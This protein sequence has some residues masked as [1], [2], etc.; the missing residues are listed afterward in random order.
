MHRL[1]ILSYIARRF[2][3][4]WKLLLSV[5]VGVLVAATLVAGAP[6]Y[7]RTLERQGLNTAIDRSPRGFLN[8]H[9]ASDYIPLDREGINGTERALDPA[10]E[11]YLEGPYLGRQRYLRAPVYY[12]G[13]PHRPLSV[14]QGDRV[15]MGHFQYMSELKDH[16]TFVEGR[17]ATDEVIQG[18]EGVIIEAVIGRRPA[19][20]L[21]LEV[22]DFATLT[23]SLRAHGYV[24]AKIV[25]ILEPIDPTSV[26]WRGNA[27]IFVSP[28]TNVQAE[29]TVN[30]DDD[31]AV[32]EGGPD[33]DPTMPPMPLFTTLASLTDGV[34]RQYPGTLVSS[35]W[36]LYMDKERLKGWSISDTRAR[37]EGLETE[38]VRSMPG[39]TVFS[40]MS[41]LVT[42]FETRNFF[43]TV[44][45]LLL[46]AIM[47]M[48]V[49]YYLS[50]MVSYLVQSR[51]KDV[52]LLRS[53]GVS[54]FQ[55]LRL[56]AVEGVA[57]IALATVLAPFIAM[58]AVAAA[59]ILPY[60][61][62]ITGGGLL[63]VQLAWE[64]FAVAA[65]AGIL[66][67]ATFVV[68][69]VVGT[70]IGLVVHRLRSSRP[71]SVPV[72]QRYY[73]DVA[74]LVIGGLIFWEL[75]SR[76]HLVAGGLFEN[77]GVN[78]ALLLAPVLFLAM[79]ALV[80]MRLFPLLVRYA[81]GES[82][83][84]LHP[85]VAAV[86]ATLASTV[87][88]SGIEDAAGLAWL[89]SVGLLG[90]VAVAYWATVR[91]R[92][93]T[94]RVWGL[95]VQSGLVGLFTVVEPP[96]IGELGFPAAV[97]LVAIV[98]AQVVFLLLRLGARIWPVSL[99][100]GLWH[101][102]R[103]PLQYSWLILLLVLVTGLGVMATT[104]GGTLERSHQERVSYVV[105][106]D[107]RISNI[108][109]YKAGNNERL[110][111]EYL[112]VPGVT[113]VTMALRGRARLG[114][115]EEA[116]PFEVLAVE[117]AFF[118]RSSWY[119]DDFSPRSLTSV[120]GSLQ[121][122][123]PVD[124]I[125]LPMG[126]T[127]LGVWIKPFDIY[128]GVSLWMVLED[129]NGWMTTLSFGGLGEP[130]WHLVRTDIPDFMEPPL[131]ILAV[132][133]TER[134]FGPTATPGTIALDD[135]HV[136]LGESGEVRV[137]D[138]FDDSKGWTPM[139][140]SVI[141]TDTLSLTTDGAH[142]GNAAVLFTFGKETDF[143][144]RG[145]YRTHHA[146]GVPVVASSSFVENTGQ[147]IGSRFVVN[148]SGRLV[149]VF[150]QD[151][152][153]YFPTLDPNGGGFLLTNLDGLMWH[154]NIPRPWA[155][156]VPND[157]FISYAPGARDVV[158]R[159]LRLNTTRLA[160]M[161]DREQLLASI[162][163]DPLITGGWK[164]MVLLSVGIILFTAGLGYVTYLLSFARRSGSEMVFL[165][166]F[167]L[168]R[169]QM[170]AH[171]GLEHLLIAAIGLGLGTWAGFQI[172]GLMVSAVAVT[173]AGRDVIP[174]YILMTDWSLL[175]PVYA[176]L[177]LFFLGAIYRLFGSMRRLD[178]QAVSRLE[179]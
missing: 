125:D 71:P 158:H 26:Y 16:V 120:M 137:L 99:S 60:F 126:S 167:G 108:P 37:I 157:V 35:S 146:G 41:T 128:L 36:L 59:G 44:P 65:G 69:G 13:L 97:G 134:G 142:R 131:Q 43:S 62:E 107:I 14:E 32:F 77:V 74:V 75:Y 150:L 25:G 51:E 173:E 162:R 117:P 89:G 130:G 52:A 6:V 136:V 123:T 8:F 55:L 106:T 93:S 56:Y 19:S 87:I 3:N 31:T 111:E 160:D 101:M 40:G 33:I 95:I 63:P 104:V 165:R 121:H 177:A 179:A 141:S 163:F 153:D 21:R 118:G 27:A 78:E 92:R 152:V 76:G 100:L 178:L 105:P 103:N 124:P 80:F 82:A 72:F 38:F 102:A 161:L 154:L 138:D 133:L 79:I 170:M 9:V 58:G 20:G 15:S 144:V 115:D 148:M 145:F 122:A 168:S 147:Q 174:P 24:S 11:T 4:D 140:T 113:A 81:S 114:N 57:L 109:S 5:F 28:E 22:G 169:L 70:R 132:Q 90:A 159:G 176:G 73:L 139:T 1:S 10:I 164:A 17:M 88:F 155:G 7:V 49:V 172:T 94:S 151:T 135:I 127:S 45:M 91:A 18:P 66:C 143:G 39:S 83:E 50:M 85:A 149:T 175:V 171:L 112:G 61:Q 119:R 48:T 129:K 29:I 46:L 110:R 53:R 64:P 12:V 96:V 2:A 47:V 166:S 34:G 30:P 84:F 116:T 42:R 67:L 68:P 23:P 86:V 54:A 156:L 98:P